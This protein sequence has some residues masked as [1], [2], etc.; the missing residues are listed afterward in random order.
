[1][2]AGKCGACK[3]EFTGLTSFDKHQ[4]VNYGRRPAVVCLD[5]ATAGL[6]KDRNGRWGSPADDASRLRLASLRAEQPVAGIPGGPEGSPSP[7]DG[8]RG[9]DA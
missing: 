6:V 8:A 5:P 7:E 1:M 9:F 2:S 4:D 3:R